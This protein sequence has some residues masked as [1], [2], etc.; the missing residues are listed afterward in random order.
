MA[1][2]TFAKLRDGSWGVSMDAGAQEGDRIT[3]VRKDGS[4]VPGTV[5]RILGRPNTEGRVL[6]T[7]VA[8]DRGRTG[9]ARRGWRPCGYPGCNPTFCDECDGQGGGR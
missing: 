5:G 6:A 2:A 9:P 1:S 4:T 3:V 7:F 8:A